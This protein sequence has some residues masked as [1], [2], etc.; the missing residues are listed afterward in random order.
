[1]ANN[2]LLDL[3]NALADAVSNA[4]PGVARVE[5]RRRLPASGV[6]WSADG[7]IVTAHHVVQRDE[8]IRVGLS[9]GR[10]VD[11]TLVGRDPTTDLALLRADAADLTPLAHAGGEGPQVGNLALALGRPGQ[12]VQATLGIVSALGGNWRTRHGGLI[13]R[14][15]QTD[16]VMYP[17]FS[18]GPLVDGAGHL[19]GLNSS[20][21]LQGISL[22][23]PV[24]TLE[25]IARTLLEDGRVRRGFLG[26]NTQQVR[27]PEGVQEE[28]AQKTGLLLVAVEKGS[29]A[30]QSGLVLGDTIVGLDDQPVRNHDDLLSLLTGDRVGTAVPIRLLRGGR[31]QTQEVTIGE[32]PA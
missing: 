14:Y 23:L 30:D 19:L 4:D 3:S 17:G 6:V 27:L 18:G 9:D 22:T 8:G 20:A 31:L 12:T 26:V 5:G 2:L 24:S 32:R 21:L 1:M 7:L 28:A 10:T 16:V 13:D 29:P 15:L 11:A 25:R